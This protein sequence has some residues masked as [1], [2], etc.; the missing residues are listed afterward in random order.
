M[1]VVATTK[2]VGSGKRYWELEMTPGTC[3]VAGVRAVNNV[4]PHRV[5]IPE[6]KGTYELQGVGAA[7]GHDS[8]IQGW[9]L[10]TGGAQPNVL[11]PTIIGPQKAGQIRL[12]FALDASTQ[13]FWIS[14]DG[15]WLK[16][17]PS[18]G[19]DGMVLPELVEHHLWHPA[20]ARLCGAGSA[21]V[22]IYLGAQDYRYDPPQGFAP[23]TSSVCDCSRAFQ[24]CSEAVG[25]VDAAVAGRI[26]EEC[27]SNGCDAARCSI[28]I[29]ELAKKDSR[30]CGPE[31]HA[32]CASRFWSCTESPCGASCDDS[33]GCGVGL[34]CKN[35]DT[36]HELS[37]GE[38]CPFS[39]C[40]CSIPK[41][42]SLPPYCGGSRVEEA[43]TSSGCECGRQMLECLRGCELDKA[44]VM[45]YTEICGAMGCT[46]QECGMCSVSCNQTQVACWHAFNLC[47][48]AASMAQQLDPSIDQTQRCECAADF[49]TCMASGACIT[50][51]IA[52][53][54]RDLCRQ[55]G[56][57]GKECG[58]PAELLAVLPENRTC[59]SSDLVCTQKYMECTAKRMDPAKD[60]CAINFV[61]RTGKF[62]C[63][64][65]RYLGIVGC[66]YDFDTDTCYTSEEC[67]CSEEYYACMSRHECID[68]RSLATFADLCAQRGCTSEQCGIGPYTCNRTA[69]VCANE[70]LQ[71][72]FEQAEE[73]TSLEYEG[74][75]FCKASFC[76]RRY[77]SCMSRALCTSEKDVMEHIHVCEDAGCTLEECGVKFEE[78]SM[79]LPD[80]PRTI[81][82]K[83]SSDGS[84]NVTWQHSN[85]AQ[86]WI[87][88]GSLNMVQ[89]YSLLLEG[90]CVREGACASFLAKNETDA[91]R[92]RE[93][94][95]DGRLFFLKV[96][97]MYKVSISATN[98]MGSGP[99]ASKYQRL[100]GVP[101]SPEGV[102][103]SQGFGALTSIIKWKPPIDSGDTT[104]DGVSIIYYIVEITASPSARPIEFKVTMTKFEVVHSVGGSWHRCAAYGEIC[105]CAG[106]ARYGLVA[107]RSTPV[108]VQRELLCAPGPFF[109]DLGTGPYFD[110]ECSMSANVLMKGQAL[111]ARVKAAN[112][113]GVGSFS[114]PVSVTILGLPGAVE[115]ISVKEKVSS[116]EVSWRQPEDSG[117]GVGNEIPAILLYMILL[118]CD[119]GCGDASIEVS[120]IKCVLGVDETR[121][122][123]A[124]SGS[125]LQAGQVYH[126]SVISQNSV[127]WSNTAAAPM[128]RLPWKISP[129]ILS[130]IGQ[131]RVATY[132]GTTTVW[133][134]NRQSYERSDYFL[135]TVQHF[136]KMREGQE[137]LFV[138]TGNGTSA[139][140]SAR[141]I[142]REVNGN[143][144][145]Q[146]PWGLFVTSTFQVHP[147]ANDRLNGIFTG[148][149]ITD[150]EGTVVEM[151]LE[152]FQYP[153]ASLITM[154][155]D[156]GRL[157][158]GEEVKI[159][160]QEPTEPQ[161]RFAASLPNF[162]IGILDGT[163]GVLFG[164]LSAEII[165]TKVEGDQITLKV[166]A[167][168][169]KWA[170]RN[171]V[172]VSF[173]LASSPI[174]VSN[175]S[176][177]QYYTY[178]GSY[179][180]G[181]TPFSGLTTGG[182]AVKLVVSD[183]GQVALD[184]LP[185][186]QFA[187]QLCAGVSFRITETGDVEIFA[188]TPQVDSVGGVE[189]SVHLKRRFSQPLALSEHG[190]FEYVAPPDPFLD[191]LSLTVDG[192]SG[193]DIYVFSRIPALVTFTLKHMHLLR[194]DPFVVN[195]GD[196]KYFSSAVVAVGLGDPTDVRF[197][198]TAFSF[199]TGQSLPVGSLA[200]SVTA[201][202]FTLTGISLEVKNAASPTIW[203]LV[204]S[205][206]RV[207]GG[208]IVLAAVSGFSGGPAVSV[209]ENLATVYG[210]VSLASWKERDSEYQ[211]LVGGADLSQYLAFSGSESASARQGLVTLLECAVA[212][213][214]GIILQSEAQLLFFLA[215]SATSAGRRDVFI[216]PFAFEYVES[217]QGPS[218]ISS[219]QPSS[220]GLA[221]GMR[222]TL[223]IRNFLMV[224]FP[225]EIAV[226]M[227][228]KTVDV[229]SIGF[230]SDLRT[231]IS[232]ILPPSS[233]GPGNVEINVFPTDMP[234]NSAL[235]SFTYVDD[236]LPLLTC[237]ACG[238]AP[239]SIY[240]SG[241]VD[242]TVVLTQYGTSATTRDDVK[243]MILVGTRQHLITS[244]TVPAVK[245]FSFENTAGE[246]TS[247]IVFTAPAVWQPAEE[248]I[249]TATVLIWHI[250][251]ARSVSTT[252]EYVKTPSG[253]AIL[254]MAPSQGPTS[255]GTTIACR[256]TNFHQISSFVLLRAQFGGTNLGSDH[257]ISVA[258]TTKETIIMLTLPPALAGETI[259]V[260]V[261]EEGKK[262]GSGTAPFK[263]V[264]NNRMQ[265]LSA[266]PPQGTSGS[267]VDVR[268]TLGNVGRVVSSPSDFVSGLDIT[269]GGSI[270]ITDIESSTLTASSITLRFIL[271]SVQGSVSIRILI[272]LVGQDR[273]AVDIPFTVIPTGAPVILDFEPTSY[274]LD[275]GALLSVRL[276][277]LQFPKQI[278]QGD[279]QI[280]FE[281]LGRVNITSLSVA[282][283]VTTVTTRLPSA[284]SAGKYEME[285]LI[286]G[287]TVSTK[288]PSQFLYT[289]PVDCVLVNIIPSRGTINVPT[290]V[291]LVVDHFPAI[292]STSDIVVQAGGHAAIITSFARTN[293]LVDPYSIQTVQISATFPY[294][295]AELQPGKVLVHVYHRRY[296]SR[297]AVSSSKTMFEYYDPELPTVES[298]IG[299]NGRSEVNLSG[300]TNV[301]ITV[302]KAPRGIG[303]ADIFA[304]I[305]A[306]DAV[307]QML[308]NL[309]NQLVVTI[310]APGSNQVQ[311]VEGRLV[312]NGDFENP[313]KFAV[314]YFDNSRA[315]IVRMSPSSGPDF[316][317]TNVFIQ[318][319]NFPIVTEI[320]S[321]TVRFG[322]SGAYFGNVLDIISSDSEMTTLK[323]QTLPYPVAESSILTSVV[324]THIR[325]ST[326]Q[327]SAYTFEFQKKRAT[328]LSL[329]PSQAT[330]MGGTNVYITVAYFPVGLDNNAIGV[331]FGQM[332]VH[333]RNISVTSSDVETT[334]MVV[335]TPASNPGVV[336]G[337]VYS[338]AS[339]E[340]SVLFDF[341]FMDDTSPTVV[342]PYPVRG[343]IDQKGQTETVWVK[344][345]PPEIVDM[346]QISVTVKSIG[347]G[348]LRSLSRE[349]E[350]TKLVI[351]MPEADVVGTVTVEV[352]TSSS[353]VVNFEY[354]FIDC[355]VAV[356]EQVAP[357]RGVNS[358]G[359]RIMIR[360]SNWVELGLPVFVVSF[361]S[362]NGAIVSERTDGSAVI[363]QV[364]TPAIDS[365]GVIDVRISG[366][367]SSLAFDYEFLLPCNYVEFCLANGLVANVVRMAK[368]PPQETESA[369]AITYCIDPAVIPYPTLTSVNPSY[370]F[371]SGGTIVTLV[372]KG[373]AAIDL[374]SVEIQVDT[375]T[376]IPLSI[377][378]VGDGAF[379]EQASLIFCMPASP[380]SVAT[381][382]IK[383]LLHFGTLR[384]FLMFRFQYIK[385]LVG[386][387]LVSDIFPS[388]AYFSK[389]QSFQVELRNF[390]QTETMDTTLIT[391]Q[392]AQSSRTADRIIE[393]STSRTIFTFTLPA[394][395]SNAGQNVGMG[396][397][398]G[399]SIFYTPHTIIRAG[400]AGISIL[401][402]PD[403]RIQGAPVPSEG[404]SSADNVLVELRAQHF[405]TG[406]SAGSFTIALISN[407]GIMKTLTIGSMVYD[408]ENCNDV[409]CSSITFRF[410]IPSN[411][412]GPRAHGSAELMLC[413]ASSCISASYRYTTEFIVELVEPTGAHSNQVTPARL[414]LKHFDVPFET[415]RVKLADINLEIDPEVIPNQESGIFSFGVTVPKFLEIGVMQ[416]IVYVEGDGTKIS[417]FK[418]TVLAPPTQ[419][420]PVDGS[421]V[422]ASIVTV[423]AHWGAMGTERDIKVTFGN[424]AGKVQATLMSNSASSAFAIVT[425]PGMIA[426]I[427][428]AELQGLAGAVALFNF[429]YYDPPVFADVQPRV[430]TLDGRVGECNGCLLDND[431]RHL[432]VWVENFPPVYSATDFEI[433]IGSHKCD[434][435]VCAVKTIKNL[436]GKLFFTVSVPAA[437]SRARV[438]MSLRYTGMP[439]PPHPAVTPSGNVRRED[440]TAVS[441][442]VGI[443]L[444]YVKPLPVVVLAQF[445]SNCNAGS[446]CIDG[447][448]CGMNE[449]PLI[450]RAMS[451]QIPLSIVLPQ[452]GGGVLTLSVSE[453]PGLLVSAGQLVGGTL[454]VIF[455]DRSGTIKRVLWSSVSETRLEVVLPEQGS[456]G[457]MTVTVTMLS[458]GGTK[459]QAA[460]LALIVDDSISVRCAASG[461]NLC[462]GPSD[463]AHPVLLNLTDF[464]PVDQ[465]ELNSQVRVRVGLVTAV[466][467]LITSA[468]PH[469][470]MFIVEVP[471]CSGCTFQNGL[472]S[473]LMSIEIFSPADKAW[474]VLTAVLFSYVAPPSVSSVRFTNA[475]SGLE[476]YFDSP[477]NRG[478]F[479][480]AT[481]FDCNEILTPVGLG[482]SPTC[483]WQNAQSLAVTFGGNPTVLP[484]D[485][486][487]LKS[488][489]I[490]SL[491]GIS[492]SALSEQR[493][494]EILA[495][496]FQAPL[497]PVIIR[498]SS[499]IDTCANLIL[500]ASVVSPRPLVFT[501]RCITSEGLDVFLRSQTGSNI[502]LSR[503]TVEMDQV[504][505]KYVITV[506]ATDFMGITS[507]IASHTVTKKTVSMPQ[508]TLTGMPL[509][510]VSDD[511]LLRADAQFSQCPIAQTPLVFEWSDLS[512]GDKIPAYLLNKNK[513]ANSAHFF[514]PASTLKSGTRYT[515][516]VAASM[517]SEP[518]RR[519]ESVFD[520]F[521]DQAP[522]LAVIDGGSVQTVSKLKHFSLDGKRSRDLGMVRLAPSYDGALPAVNDGLSYK[523]TCSILTLPC[524]SDISQEVI[525]FANK[526]S[527]R[528]QA[529]T[530]AVSM[531]VPYQFTLTVSKGTRTHSTVSALYVHPNPIPAIGISNN[532]AHVDDLGIPKINALDR[533][534][535]YGFSDSP[536]T[537]F[538]WS[539]SPSVPLPA[540]V[541]P[542]GSA[543]ETLVLVPTVSQP[544]TVPGGTY[545]LKLEG[546]TPGGTGSAQITVVVNAPP[547]PGSCNVC[548][549][550]SKNECLQ[551]GR[552]LVDL[553]KIE[554]S[555][556]SDENQ[557]LQYRYGIKSPGFDTW[558]SS[559]G[560]GSVK[561]VMLPSGSIEVSV[562]IVD[563]LGASA[564]SVTQTVLLS[565]FARRFLT[566]CIVYQPIL[567]NVDSAISRS[568]AD[569]INQFASALA[570][571]MGRVGASACTEIRSK[572]VD[573][574][575][576]GIAAAA[577]TTDFAEEAGDA[578]SAVTSQPCGLTVDSALS[579]LALVKQL[580]SVDT[581]GRA[582]KTT[583]GKSLVNTISSSIG[584]SAAGMCSASRTYTT[585]QAKTV[586]NL[587]VDAASLVMMA[588]LRQKLVGEPS[589]KTQAE[590]TSQLAERTTLRKVSASA[591]GVKANRRLSAVASGAAFVLNST[592]ASQIGL[593][594]ASQAIDIFRSDDDLMEGVARQLS[595]IAFMSSVAVG[596]KISTAGST[597]HLKVQN[598]STPIDVIIPVDP[599]KTAQDLFWKQKVNCAWYDTIDGVWSFSGCE[600]Y[601]V[602]DLQIH[603]KCNHLTQFAI[604]IDPAVV[605]CGDGQ[606][607]LTEECDDGNKVDNDGCS[608]S[609]KVE[610]GAFCDVQ[611][612][613]VCLQACPPGQYLA[614]YKIQVMRIIVKGAC[615]DCPALEYKSAAE[616]YATTCTPLTL[617]PAGREKKWFPASLMGRTDGTCVPCKK[618]FYKPSNPEGSPLDQCT[619]CPGFSIT[620]VQGSH[621]ERDC[622]CDGISRIQSSTSAT[623]DCVYA[624]SCGMSPGACV[625]DATCSFSNACGTKCKCPAFHHGN[626]F[627]VGALVFDV[628][629]GAITGT[630]C[631][632]SGNNATARCDPDYF[633]GQCEYKMPIGTV[634]SY[635]VKDADANGVVDP[636]SLQGFFNGVEVA[637]IDGPAGFLPTSYVENTRIDIS[638]LMREDLDLLNPGLS[639]D[640]SWMRSNLSPTDTRYECAPTGA[641][642]AADFILKLK[643]AGLSF[644]VP[645]QLRI[646]AE[647]V[648]GSDPPRYKHVMLFDEGTNTWTPLGKGTLSD[649]VSAPLEHFSLYASGAGAEVERTPSPPSPPPLPPPSPGIVISDL[650]SKPTGNSTAPPITKSESST[651]VLIAA[652]V[653]PF[654]CLMGAAA[655]F[656][657]RKR[658]IGNVFLNKIAPEDT[659][660]SIM[661]TP[662][663]MEARG[664]DE[665]GARGPDIPEVDASNSRPLSAPLTA[666]LIVASGVKLNEWNSCR[667][668][669]VSIYI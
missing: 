20:A 100:A 349:R 295:K 430:S 249:W 584:S 225:H 154:L 428:Q 414:Y 363:L 665:P 18:T 514:I 40:R 515:V 535:F 513:Q 459:L 270:W 43:G 182:Q 24:Q 565:S 215:P 261:F 118:K 640:P 399:V 200:I 527:I 318:L 66:N 368:I 222:V 369:C 228:Q 53:E 218:T 328:V 611:S 207:S 159:V 534:M 625:A 282:S 462:A 251:T 176:R 624:D 604:A 264:D 580:A 38:P 98:A 475:G 569:E 591:G 538:S 561:Q 306:I 364:E 250:P 214:R 17:N 4:D 230:S 108:S 635:A 209:G 179:I 491:D 339:R 65:P 267:V 117:F 540:S 220:A 660:L 99:S 298:V 554:C 120:P 150:L 103:A 82:A 79:R 599:S 407:S 274:P 145:L 453:L 47:D 526:G 385:A 582:I 650:P 661:Q 431:G 72:G 248:T 239:A 325:Y 247:T 70:Y 326:Q 143:G 366:S 446:S 384:R 524:R 133:K 449:S 440:K 233:S 386:K 335:V 16:G 294:N 439:I 216:G 110:C 304:E 86:Q 34:V 461:S 69:L 263:Y 217:P 556:W 317:G 308:L 427:V 529:G 490:K 115:L 297:A 1:P 503:G 499:Q 255:G 92:L 576:Q 88:T 574:L 530:L 9:A 553:F 465:A 483:M 322:M 472:L 578:L 476:V 319:T 273:K 605:I 269:W 187:G 175:K 25:C 555:L 593:A 221:G 464:P 232:F 502:V 478:G 231:E 160:L 403:P 421:I 636:F 410:R 390:P 276:T 210:A 623:I 436:V 528:V 358:G 648:P 351:E 275:G 382:D 132:A 296:S 312:F 148:R 598:L 455:G 397:I 521:I 77:F 347:T 219:I 33:Q 291:T 27:I 346:S 127:G 299:E 615:T 259:L 140:G 60:R 106:F 149:L 126:V 134:D 618:G 607:R 627:I 404:L 445:C 342:A 174:E 667:S 377:S 288:F 320:N 398:M 68:D 626:G 548:K 246:E 489:A 354:M 3:V 56:C 15:V 400:N 360:I 192:R 429:E 158:G 647:G 537:R 48:D 621:E 345:F 279:I 266:S 142:S 81:F 260:T 609:C 186:V 75:L 61:G 57:S 444:E 87:R 644:A 156:S 655:L 122:T 183:L 51:A 316:G 344:L 522:L 420:E 67:S 441:S 244:G 416:G 402:D 324:V 23:F 434:G 613:S 241:G 243:V 226:Q 111:T 348:Q 370:G 157:G 353:G 164:K 258:S 277:S 424:V 558:W 313:L 190:L 73:G 395:S 12:G 374:A 223:E 50:N 657:Y 458:D 495:P 592:I 64:N 394:R 492:P 36:F 6:Y 546:T 545:V 302:S 119:A 602:S 5:F 590:F 583:L 664:N 432:N 375:V 519:S 575:E 485:S 212:S 242:V 411:P 443:F 498:A 234:Q 29:E 482:T 562:E 633:G 305:N 39:R 433:T 28:S 123:D 437:Q 452:V 586:M 541:A 500:S 213:S 237:F 184:A 199:L 128:Q 13:R 567:D 532:I 173:L 54:H 189:V 669:Q 240:A 90:N 19:T 76:L 194:T 422:G 167:P 442:A 63:S 191:K 227:G 425:P 102:A 131:V 327:S 359:T 116:V 161:T 466:P 447:G 646:D 311:T 486:L 408:N 307:V 543:H 371:A 581:R 531:N 448:M 144:N 151:L 557:P 438:A 278:Q 343:C 413:T 188:T 202:G 83:S 381:L 165:S 272:S 125:L 138:V 639:P 552:S 181:V 654:I 493:R 180:A 596:F 391:V 619:R 518:Y 168:E 203:S 245:S 550:S 178:R 594:D 11:Y 153:K 412:D 361:M 454:S 201:R 89:K 52:R 418:F 114:T 280:A 456:F 321:V 507:A 523:W 71:C 510:Q 525:S 496:A 600:R 479:K 628:F 254:E 135:L 208:S 597:T 130:P 457:R 152:Y 185:E 285:V 338:K 616:N 334:I 49:Y 303:Q 41:G 336:R 435:T 172:F 101:G 656:I 84:L 508:F 224:Y 501:W 520:I 352:M 146:D 171:S 666:D 392:F 405:R 257:I 55:M 31:L 80:E 497:G 551:S 480:Q 396:I 622:R 463:R 332:H 59:V 7:Y 549:V 32:L 415:I 286:F 641:S 355:S 265:V 35:V 93:L 477:T 2:G 481:V 284:P 262:S 105:A 630:G 379:A 504:D 601:D 113:L 163:L 177:S 10:M 473:E 488:D 568:R 315:S 668:C 268:V 287:G 22:K 147:P 95:Y 629:Y 516:Q 566:D 170:E 589:V 471:S 292:S 198:Q 58:I 643:P 419:I 74:D 577:S 197:A 544:I 78:E 44:A 387:A 252:I 331:E 401:S 467:Q 652:I 517:M 46:P 365:I 512:A 129:K 469:G 340:T 378:H 357:T 121:C 659:E 409:V 547:Q 45:E 141:L 620:T 323:V 484:G 564:M 26:Y 606:R 155:A 423:T 573:A 8:R 383:L 293:P 563:N 460:F 211:E 536:D 559:L 380:R 333:P 253:S 539:I 42:D 585:D 314:S 356:I 388:S 206:S 290:P 372:G 509:Y 588:S 204:P 653:V 350:L 367:L 271:P 94:T 637:S 595:A 468:G 642:L 195:V 662:L 632:S 612:P 570:H 205:Q 337:R 309:G 124:V 137:I 506:T 362:F 450:A 109:P 341:R 229:E 281:A 571:E 376:G 193:G 30:D 658:I 634:F 645:V 162:F 617:C 256:L 651:G 603:C 330:V 393:S 373:F 451:S 238:I 487:M 587:K 104:P 470:T 614:G 533:L 494:A 301:R 37:V 96:G 579:S 85:L 166:V 329:A 14:R 91:L 310:V 406:L 21:T 136:P 196:I 283:G 235:R 417:A 542:L 505:W 608:A 139:I 389:S 169:S 511:V 474:N 289:T 426:G 112:Y 610:P 236:R 300:G 62:S 631:T 107:M 97:T 560:F 663:N 572:L 649:K 638:V